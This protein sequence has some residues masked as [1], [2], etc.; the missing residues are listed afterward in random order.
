[1]VHHSD[2]EPLT[3][4]K[5]Q[6]RLL[7][8][9]QDW[10]D[11]RKMVAATQAR[12]DRLVAELDEDRQRRVEIDR[13]ITELARHDRRS[14]GGGQSARNSTTQGSES[15]DERRAEP[16]VTAPNV[17]QGRREEGIEDGIPADQIA[18]ERHRATKTSANADPA[19][20]R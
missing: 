19:L 15:D 1:M 7:N 13:R 20:S 8:A 12:L 17:G 3:V 9:E 18:D 5:L 4:D 6:E 2:A 16:S 10:S 14:G 11:V